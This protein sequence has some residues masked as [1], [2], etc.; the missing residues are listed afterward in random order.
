MPLPKL[1]N[2]EHSDKLEMCQRSAVYVCE[3]HAAPEHLGRLGMRLGGI[4][5]LFSQCVH[6][7]VESVNLS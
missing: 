6:H 4:A 7:A 5:E 2:A 3:S 1:G